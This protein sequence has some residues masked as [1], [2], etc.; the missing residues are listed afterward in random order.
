MPFVTEDLWQRLPNINKLTDVPSIM[1]SSY[2]E[3]NDFLIDLVTETATDVI[4]QTINSARS[5]R[6]EYKIASNIKVDYYFVSAEESVI[7][8]L[9]SQEDDFCTLAKGNF[10][11]KTELESA[12]KGCCVKVLSEHLTL[13]I[14][15]TGVIDLDQEIARLNKEI[16]RLEPLV[17]SY[18]RKCNADA[19][20]L[21][22][23][24]EAVKIAQAEKLSTY[25]NELAA[26]QEAI[27][28]FEKM[29]L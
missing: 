9:T 14:E 26:V 16:V 8:A 4:R 21:D 5:I 28:S 25:E 22:K 29:K 10:L 20:V 23:L 13:L 12:P 1:I 15:L 6:A 19:D 24:P 18:A 27:K 3:D 17:A 11:K 7:S 2:P